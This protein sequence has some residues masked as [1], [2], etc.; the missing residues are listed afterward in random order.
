MRFGKWMAPAVAAI[1]IGVAGSANAASLGSLL[2]VESSV[3]DVTETVTDF[4]GSGVD[5]NIVSPSGGSSGGGSDAY[6]KASSGGGSC[7]GKVTT[8]PSCGGGVG[9]SLSPTSIT[10]AI[11]INITINIDIDLDLDVSAPPVGSPC[12][13]VCFGF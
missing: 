9:G 13:C 5:I 10:L 6:S 4:V 7:G 11:T 2:G 8:P 1:A 3:F 12:R